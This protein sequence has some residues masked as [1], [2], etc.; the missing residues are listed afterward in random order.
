MDNTVEVETVTQNKY[1]IV[2][3]DIIVV[4]TDLYLN[5]IFT[6]LKIPSYF[7]VYINNNI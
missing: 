3:A 7:F 6:V 1:C 5:L 4:S 2:M